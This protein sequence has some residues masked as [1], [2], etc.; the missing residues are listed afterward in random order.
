MLDIHN[1]SDQPSLHLMPILEPFPV[2]PKGWNMLFN[3][4][5]WV[6]SLPMLWEEWCPLINKLTHL[7]TAHGRCRRAILEMK[8]C[9][10]DWNET[11]TSYISVFL[12]VFWILCCYF[13]GLFILL[14]TLC[15]RSLQS[16]IFIPPRMASW[17]LVFV[18]ITHYFGW[19]V[20][21]AFWKWKMENSVMSWYLVGLSALKVL[22]P[23][24]NCS[25]S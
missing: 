4:Q 13:K 9:G 1:Y 5:A 16:G 20:C 11:D 2:T 6:L 25:Y 17:T 18:P 24:I 22:R 7:P 19:Q 3:W 10:K 12:R 8:G 15:W 21:K 23:R 14:F